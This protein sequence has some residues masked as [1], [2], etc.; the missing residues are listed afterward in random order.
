MQLLFLK[1]C[2][3]SNQHFFKGYVYDV[4]DMKLASEFI[5]IGYAEKY[6]ADKKDPIGFKERKKK[7]KKGE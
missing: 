5:R 7:N 6:E 2:V 3:T 4:L 1:S